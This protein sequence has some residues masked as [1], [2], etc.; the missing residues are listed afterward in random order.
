M[1]LSLVVGVHRGEVQ[2]FTQNLYLVAED[3]SVEHRVGEHR[4][5]EEPVV[6]VRI[7][8]EEVDHVEPQTDQYAPKG[9]LLRERVPGEE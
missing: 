8:N 4:Y 7:D 1:E 2:H 9:Y 6:V 3:K 5:G